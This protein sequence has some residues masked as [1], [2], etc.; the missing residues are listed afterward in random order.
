MRPGDLLYLPRGQFHDALASSD[1]S[2]H[3]TFSCSEPIG[4]EWLTK[5]WELAVRDPLFRADL[6]PCGSAE[7]EA[8]FAQHLGSLSDRFQQIAKGPE[9]FKL[10]Q[11]LRNGFSVKR[12]SF[13]LPLFEQP[14]RFRVA[15]GDLKVVRRGTQWIAQDANVKSPQSEEDAPLVSWMAE[16]GHFDRSALVAA[17]PKHDEQTLDRLLRSLCTAGLLVLVTS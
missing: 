7:D 12:S 2:L 13:A 5:L 3:V 10:A 9:A 6:P 8:A 4:L 14:A 17:F 16:H 15:R 11:Q 1:A